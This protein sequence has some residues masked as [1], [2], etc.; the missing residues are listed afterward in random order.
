MKKVLLVFMVFIVYGSSLFAYTYGTLTVGGD[1]SGNFSISTENASNLISAV[2][3]IS[4]GSVPNIN[5]N[6]TINFN[7]FQNKFFLENGGFDINI[8]TNSETNTV[9][10]LNGG[11]LTLR[12]VQKNQTYVLEF[13]NLIYNFSKSGGDNNCISGNL[14]LNGTELSCAVLNSNNINSKGLF[15]LIF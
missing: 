3:I 4:G 5:T 11:P 8:K 12:D 9:V 10:T 6:A 13:H 15:L 2:T 7:N 14:E 1:K